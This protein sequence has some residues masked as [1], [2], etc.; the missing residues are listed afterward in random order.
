MLVF[1]YIYIEIYMFFPQYSECRERKKKWG[2]Q[3]A[4]SGKCFEKDDFITQLNCTLC[5]CERLGVISQ[6]TGQKRK[7]NVN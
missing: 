3:I 1:Q 6:D 5:V 7:K 2:D 4:F